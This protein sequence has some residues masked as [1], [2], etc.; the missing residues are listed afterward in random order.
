MSLALSTG[1]LGSCLVLL[2]IW[3]HAGCL[4]KVSVSEDD[5]ADAGAG[6]RERL[7]T[8]SD[9]NVTSRSC[10]NTSECPTAQTCCRAGLLGSCVSLDTGAGCPLPDLSVS[11]LSGSL[12]IE[13]RSFATDRAADACALEWQ[14]VRAAGSRKLLRFGTQATNTGPADLLLGAPSSTPGFER[15]ACD[16]QPY[17]H[18][19]LRYTLLVPN[20]ATV[21]AD[22]HM[23]ASCRAQATP[24]SLVS[25]FDCEFMGLWHGFSEIYD[26][27]IADCQWVD[28]TDVPPG[29]YQ[30][31]ISIN[32][33]RQLSESDYSNNTLDVSIIL[34][35]GDPLSPCPV[36]YDGLS[37]HG[38]ARECGW[39][40]A[41][42]PADAGA[43][44]VLGAPCTPGAAVDQGC[45]DCTGFPMLRACD[46]STTCPAVAALAA[47]ITPPRGTCPVVSFTC[48]DSGR[49]SLLVAAYGVGEARPYDAFWNQP[50]SCEFAAPSEDSAGAAP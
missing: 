24:A 13:T 26:P 11:V 6:A 17:F 32:P 5:T 10:S 28:I 16:G 1:K 29:N 40:F 37:G 8:G 3:V 14:C 25:R 45:A 2:I 35:D 34:P 12:S 42:R 33:E 31:H 44:S 48:P 50:P 20:S 22:G 49:Y 18:E 21:V 36:P 46:G 27:G 19:Y 9:P 23:P 15:A 4:P 30:L 7:N 43:A 39:S 38:T 41:T 47:A